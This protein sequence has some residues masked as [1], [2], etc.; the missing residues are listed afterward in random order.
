MAAH[1]FAPVRAIDREFV[2]L[3][4]R[5]VGT[6]ASTNP[7][8]SLSKRAGVTS[9]A[10]TGS[11]GKY[12]VTLDAKYQELRAAH[13]TVLDPTVPDDWEVT[14]EVDLTANTNTFTISCWKGGVA[15]D[16]STD[17]TLMLTMILK[18]SSR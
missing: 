18:N 10:Q 1:N 16:L 5:G 12:L 14:V 2:I 15:A 8:T 3:S 4:C 9:I 6:G 7:L 17:E 11:T 13:G